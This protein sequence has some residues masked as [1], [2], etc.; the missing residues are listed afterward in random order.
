[1]AKLEI[2]EIAVK[3]YDKDQIISLATSLLASAKMRLSE[4]LTQQNL[5]YVGEAEATAELA[6][7]MSSA[8][9]KKTESI[10]KQPLTV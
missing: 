7:K 5:G 2:G 1:M 10:Q 3:N 8:Q 9:E 6:Y 4:A